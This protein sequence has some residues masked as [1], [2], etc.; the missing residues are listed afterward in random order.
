MVDANNATRGTPMAYGPGKSLTGLKALHVAKVPIS[1][2]ATKYIF[3]VY[4]LNG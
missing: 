2:A 1:A 3:L 4:L